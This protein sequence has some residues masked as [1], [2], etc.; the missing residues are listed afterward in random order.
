MEMTLTAICAEGPTTNPELLAIADRVATVVR[1]SIVR[2]RDAFN[3]GAVNTLPQRGIERDTFDFLTQ[4][5]AV[6]GPAVERLRGL[7]VGA[8]RMPRLAIPGPLRAFS[9]LS[10][11]APETIVDQAKAAKLFD[12]LRLSSQTLAGIHWDAAAMKPVAPSDNEAFAKAIV[13]ALDF[14][15]VLFQSPAPAAPAP[16]G[17]RELRLKLAE[18][19]SLRRFG[20]EV[21]DWGADHIVCGGDGV[22]SVEQQVR[23]P[24]FFIH[25]FSRDGEAF[26]INP[27][28]TFLKFDL[29]RAGA[30]PRSF[31]ATVSIAE[32]DASGGFIDFLHYWELVP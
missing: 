5:K 1:L 27:D 22:D 29:N 30:W 25:E 11:T 26:D 24:Q 2:G 32:Q 13:A 7:A 18:L 15:R 14:K 12:G 6:N 17:A 16:A 23:A 21:T 20:F 4:Y 10:F 19:K 28:H 8:G 9:H 31:M 3:G